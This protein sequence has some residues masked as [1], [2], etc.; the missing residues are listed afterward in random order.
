MKSIYILLGFVLLFLVCGSFY[1]T[2]IRKI[3]PTYQVATSTPVGET[4]YLYREYGEV[5]YKNKTADTFTVVTNAKITIA[6]YATVKTGDGRGYVIFPDN[7]SITLSS[8]TEIEI[9]YEPSRVSIMHLLGSTY[10]RVTALAT[11]NKYE[12]RTPNTLAAIRGTKLA[13]TYNPK[14]KKTYVAVTESTVEVTPT[15]EDGSASKAP[16]MVSEGS[17]ADVQTSTTSQKTGTSTQNSDVKMVI[18]TNDEVKEIKLF[19]DEQIIIDKEYDK[20]PLQ[21]QKEFFEKIIESLQTESTSVGTLNPDDPVTQGTKNETRTDTV[22]RA[23]KQAINTS[24]TISATPSSTSTSPKIVDPVPPVTTRTEAE[25]Q[26]P[27]KTITPTVT[28]T[29][30]LIPFPTN[31][32][33]FTPEQE[34]FIDFFYAAY[35]RYFY[36]NDPATYCKNLGTTDAKEM[37]TALLT[38]TNNAGFILP[39]QMELTAFATDLVSSCRDGSITSKAESFRTRFDVSYPY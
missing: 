11:G 35:E 1:Y 27:P 19:I 12:V 29:R 34:A 2:N 31:Q 3:D 6:N 7:S 5:S 32:E 37:V 33:I 28:E 26:L 39:N 24:T 9:S 30:P 18:R 13:V 21:E 16:V 17:L 36:V 8:S 15:K 38:K 4:I 23:V 20:T 14:I 22:T 10:H 25:I